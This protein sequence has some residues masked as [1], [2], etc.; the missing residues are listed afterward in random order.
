MNRRQ[1]SSRVAGQPG[2][3]AHMKGPLIASEI[4][5][6]SRKEN[7]QVSSEIMSGQNFTNTG[8]LILS[9]SNGQIGR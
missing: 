9:F 8:K 4:R 2:Y 1:N 3:R 6:E 5:I 7:L